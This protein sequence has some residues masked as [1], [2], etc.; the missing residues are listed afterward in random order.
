L[1]DKKN[2]TYEKHEKELE[3]KYK[4]PEYEATDSSEEPRSEGSS[5]FGGQSAYD[6]SF[7]LLLS[8]TSKK[9]VADHDHDT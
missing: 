6:G 8:R 9:R 4:H 1:E 3:E 7:I 5:A 2:G